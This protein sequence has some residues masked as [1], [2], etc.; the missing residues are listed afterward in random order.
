MERVTLVVS[1]TLLA[2]G[3][4]DPS[5]DEV[6]G[7]SESSESESTESA[8][9]ESG[10]SE[11]T[12]SGSTETDSTETGSTESETETT[13]S[14]TGEPPPDCMID[15]D[16]NLWT[17][18]CGP[19]C[20]YIPNLFEHYFDLLVEGSQIATGPRDCGAFGFEG[21]VL[22]HPSPDVWVIDACPC[23]SLC[24]DV[25]PHTIDLALF[26]E[27][28]ALDQLP[29]ELGECVRVDVWRAVQGSILQNCKTVAVG[30]Y[31]LDE[32]E[33][34]LIYAQ[35]NDTS[36]MKNPVQL[37]ALSV[38]RGPELCSG[39][40]SSNEWKHFS[41]EFTLDDVMAIVPHQN[42]TV[43][44]HPSGEYELRNVAANDEVSQFLELVPVAM[45]SVRPLP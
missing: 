27:H 29:T 7:E 19:E 4:G 38:A 16:D 17:L 6:G 24:I 20:S 40:G 5:A 30:L 18:P 13:E 36:D 1:L 10:T 31:S 39:S 32:P 12:E 3:P 11:S 21:T 45:W 23:G 26:D 35:G 15:F 2:C 8:S 25:D 33:P 14:E 43:L 42:L 34:R 9:T 28:P 41:L 22:E 37:G 44:A